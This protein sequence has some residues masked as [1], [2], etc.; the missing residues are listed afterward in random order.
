MCVC[1]IPPWKVVG[2]LCT[3]GNWFC[4]AAHEVGGVFV[5][6]TSDADVRLS[7]GHVEHVGNWHQTRRW[8]VWHIMTTL[9]HLLTPNQSSKHTQIQILAFSAV[10][11]EI[12]IEAGLRQK[13][14]QKLQIFG[15][16]CAYIRT[17]FFTGLLLSQ[18]FWF[19][20]SNN[21]W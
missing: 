10:A 16:F 2:Y 6:V 7:P 11:L 4:C 13:I 8:G 5:S 18:C 21:D 1:G 9:T 15:V 17:A 3:R 20:Y 19:K 14:C 12:T